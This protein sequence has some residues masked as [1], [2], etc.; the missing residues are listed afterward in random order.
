MDSPRPLPEIT[1]KT[2]CASSED[3]WSELPTL[4]QITRSP[5]AIPPPVVIKHAA[6]GPSLFETRD[7]AAHSDNLHWWL[8][9]IIGSKPGRLV[10]HS[11]V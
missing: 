10:F 7:P 3:S 5:D 6:T 2:I 9:A 4:T 11:K 8:Q 1:K